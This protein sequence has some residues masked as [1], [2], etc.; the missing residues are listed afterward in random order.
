MKIPTFL[1]TILF[2]ALISISFF[3]KAQVPPG[4]VPANGIPVL[5][6]ATVSDLNT[7]NGYC[8]LSYGTSGLPRS[9]TNCNP[10]NLA[11]HQTGNS[12]NSHVVITT[13]TYDSLACYENIPGQY[14]STLP[15]IT[16]WDTLIYGPLRVM[17]LGDEQA[18]SYPFA[19]AASTYY[20]T[21][22][23]EQNLLFLW[24]AFVTEAAQHHDKSENGL[25]R[26]EL[27]D[28]N[29]N[30]VTGNYYTS[31]LYVIPETTSDPILHPC[32]QAQYLNF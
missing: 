10:L 8:Q 23:E 22:T 32:C 13:S 3:S 15:S 19:S 29:G 26:I 11:G 12:G 4:I 1:K 5:V 24:V 16:F 17:Q 6:P 14:L 18:G 7:P 31:T 9:I 20:F 28:L 27:T 21:P 2:V 25:F 30:Y